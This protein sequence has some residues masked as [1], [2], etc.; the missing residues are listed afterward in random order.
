[1]EGREGTHVE[2]RGYNDGD[3]GVND[4]DD[5][6]NI[7]GFGASA[8]ARKRRQSQQQQQQQ[9]NHN[10]EIYNNSKVNT[11]TQELIV[12]GGGGERGGK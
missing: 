9:L 4:D 12:M 8:S 3:N 2:V 7:N 10:K 6:F 5:H 11:M 1:M